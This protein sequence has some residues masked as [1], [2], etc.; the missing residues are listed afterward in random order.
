MKA[1]TFFTHFTFMK[2]SLAAASHTASAFERL[3]GE[4]GRAGAAVVLGGMA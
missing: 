1:G 2:S 3:G 4:L